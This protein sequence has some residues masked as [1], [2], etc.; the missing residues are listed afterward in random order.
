MMVPGASNRLRYL[1]NIEVVVRVYN[2]MGHSQPVCR[3]ISALTKVCAPSCS[4]MWF[5]WEEMP[6]ASKVIIAS[7]V[8]CG[9]SLEETEAIFGAKADVSRFDISRGCHVTVIESGKFLLPVSGLSRGMDLRPYLSSM[10][11]MSSLLPIP[12]CRP[13]FISSFL[14]ISPSPS[15]SPVVQPSLVLITGAWLES[16]TTA[17][18]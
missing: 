17:Q 13:L 6:C 7:I 14:R 15:T 16:H 9:A 8:A 11:N 1:R 4:D 12:S 18:T 2:L 3:C 10:I 5:G